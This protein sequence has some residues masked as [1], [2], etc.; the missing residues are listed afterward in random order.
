VIL[1]ATPLLISTFLG[2]CAL[3]PLDSGFGPIWSET[4]QSGIA[5]ISSIARMPAGEGGA[6]GKLLAAD[7]AGAPGAPAPQG[8]LKSHES[9]GPEDVSSQDT[10]SQ[11]GWIRYGLLY[12]AYAVVGLPRDL[13]ACALEPAGYVT[14]TAVG[15]PLNMVLQ[16]L[17]MAYMQENR[18]NRKV[19]RSITM[20]VS[21]PF[22]FTSDVFCRS[23]TGD[24][25]RWRWGLHPFPRADHRFFTNYHAFLGDDADE[26]K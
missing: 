21:S 20:G 23:F 4:P 26:A 16:P 7:P 6:A 15:V 11:S 22:F 17:M 13:V 25:N 9:I 2:G 18:T 14:G 12:P 10:G 5:S 24:T 1:A 3:A 19:A 8:P